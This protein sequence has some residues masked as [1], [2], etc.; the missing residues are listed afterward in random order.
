[1]IAGLAAALRR[2]GLTSL[3]LAHNRL[4]PRA[5]ALLADA[6]ERTSQARA[7][8]Q[9]GWRGWGWSGVAGVGWRK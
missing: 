1:V 9:S 3:D 5:A 7:R 6:V 4:G 8:L 2:C